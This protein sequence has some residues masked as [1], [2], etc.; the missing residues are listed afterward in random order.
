[1]IFLIDI[2]I[3]TFITYFAINKSI[4]S[5]LLTEISK[6]IAMIIGVLGA[7]FLYPVLLQN[8]IINL[9]SSLFD[10]NNNQIDANFFYM[11]SFFIQ[12]FI[13]YFIVY[14]ILTHIENSITF[15]FQSN[16][17]MKKINTGQL[18]AYLQ[19]L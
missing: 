18:L 6:L 1:M 8:L 11:T 7:I 12:F 3:L 15:N 16:S 5:N 17:L 4:K 14:N 9:F 13:I 19:I 10:I 2:L